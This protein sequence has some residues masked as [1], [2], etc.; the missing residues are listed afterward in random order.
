MKSVRQL[1]FKT[2]FQMKTMNPLWHSNVDT[3][4]KWV[5]SRQ[6]CVASKG[7]C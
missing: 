5:L 4:A 2:K 6:I 7:C 3:L 1:D